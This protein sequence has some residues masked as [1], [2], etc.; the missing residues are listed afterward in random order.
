MKNKLTSQ[1]FIG[2]LFLVASSATAQLSPQGINPTPLPSRPP[3]LP[4]PTPATPPA[5]ADDNVPVVVT[6]GNGTET[7]VQITR[8]IMQP[9]GIPPSQAVTVTLFLTNAI[10]GTLV[11]LGLFDGGQIAAAVAAPSPPPTGAAPLDNTIPRITVAA[12]QTVRFNFQSD[13]PLGLYRVLLTIGPKQYLMQFFAV[14]PRPI[15]GL[16]STPPP[17]TTPPPDRPPP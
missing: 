1:A 5:N 9:V 17:I 11:H 15:P 7:H 4:S 14:N 8:G 16:I 12:D 2:L 6:Y 13:G 3:P 10:P